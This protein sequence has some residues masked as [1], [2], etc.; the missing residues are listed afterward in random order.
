M[1]RTYTVNSRERA[2]HL[3][4][5]MTTIANLIPH[6]GDARKEL[7][8]SQSTRRPTKVARPSLRSPFQNPKIVPT[9]DERI[10]VEIDHKTPVANA[11]LTRSV[12]DTATASDTRS[13]TAIPAH[14]GTYRRCPVPSAKPVSD[15]ASPIRPLK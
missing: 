13:E 14:T 12:S 11:R 5:A 10:V 4:D 3:P 8:T 15:T 6:R 9:C 7:A 1:P 2:W